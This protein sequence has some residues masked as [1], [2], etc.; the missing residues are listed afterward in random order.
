[1]IKNKID[2]KLI[3]F[4]VITLIIYLIY[5]TGGLWIGVLSKIGAIIFPFFLA[6]I[7]AYAMYPI[8]TFLKE[9]GVPK[10]I[11][12]FIIITFILAL[13]GFI[14]ILVIPNL[15]TQLS[16]LF[17]G[18]ITFLK[19]ISI[20]Y[21][22]NIG[23]IQRT[24]TSTFNDIIS[25]MGKYVSDGAISVIGISIEYLS[26]LLISFAAGIYFLIDMDEI[27]EFVKK[28]L[29]KKSRRAFLY[30]R[31]LDTEMKKYL[32]GFTK[33]VFITIF[34]YTFVYLII[35]HP[36]ALL[37]GFL[38]AI[39]GLIP[40]FGG[41]A[42]NIIAAITAFVISP[43]LF[44]RTVIAFIILSSIDGYVINP[45]VYGKTNEVHPLLVI[46][47][48]FAGGI[49]FGIF[50]VIISLPL[51]IIIIST[52]NY[53]RLDINEYIEEIKVNSKKNKRRKKEI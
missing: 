27:R 53:F 25:K 33:I 15:F 39:A 38:A 51:V 11:A 43:A 13:F 47:S 21:D 40:Y 5:H 22:L 41:M 42:T 48:V 31:R 23:E 16:E 29:N 7:F 19:E 3:N 4:A 46:L 50:G 35:G 49:L 30:I 10:G 45:L 20:D 52:Y 14:I 36:N 32:I 18:I 6:F 28:H 26:I 17:N 34:E 1:M 24:L 37:L 9:R 12:V 8:L 2:F 44:V